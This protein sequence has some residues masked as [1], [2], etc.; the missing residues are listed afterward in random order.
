[1]NSKDVCFRILHSESEREV[2]RI[3]E[4][5]PDLS[6]ALNWHP[7]DGRDTNFNVVTNQALTESKAHTELRTNMVDVVPMKHAHELAMSL[8]AGTRRNPPSP[9]SENS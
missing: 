1:M 5:L 9:E 8:T 2:D 3:V 7:M 4:S 6:D